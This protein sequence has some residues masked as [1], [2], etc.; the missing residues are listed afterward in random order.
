MQL[1]ICCLV[2]SVQL[3]IGSHFS[4][5]SSVISLTLTTVASMPKFSIYTTFAQSE[6]NPLKRAFTPKPFYFYSLD[7]L[8]VGCWVTIGIFGFQA[9]NFAVKYL[10]WYGQHLN[11]WVVISRGTLNSRTMSALVMIGSCCNSELFLAVWNNSS[12]P[13]PSSAV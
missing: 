12:R 4:S 6:L 7:F 2:Y 10:K 5:L 13:N 11:L 1:S 9:D 3:W 8:V